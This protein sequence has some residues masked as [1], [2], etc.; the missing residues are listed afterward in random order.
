MAARSHLGAT[1][2]GTDL[3]SIYNSRGTDSCFKTISSRNPPRNWMRRIYRRKSERR[4]KRVMLSICTKTAEGERLE[5]RWL[6]GRGLAL[7][8]L[9]PRLPPGMCK[10]R[11]RST[12]CRSMRL[13]LFLVDRS[14][15]FFFSHKEP[16]RDAESLSR[17]GSRRRISRT[18]KSHESPNVDVLP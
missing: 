3:L 15:H 16:Q 2:R 8:L 10:H 1:V 5:A 11:R 9:I 6:G 17:L 7:K 13:R 18:M 12:S 4:G 14:R